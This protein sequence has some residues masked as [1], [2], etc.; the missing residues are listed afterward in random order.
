MKLKFPK[1]IRVG[2]TQYTVVRKYTRLNALGQISYDTRM[3][4]IAT[5]DKFG[6]PLSTSEQNELF[7]HEL[8]HGIL[9]D[10]GHPL[11]DNE[12]FVDAFA[13]RLSGAVESA[14]F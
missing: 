12:R 1:K 11:C 10:M 7:W 3:I 9:R 6:T 4:A 14:E 2:K 13:R 8:T 5:R